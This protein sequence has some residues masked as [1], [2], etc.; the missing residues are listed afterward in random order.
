MSELLEFL[1]HIGQLFELPGLVIRSV[2]EPAVR[3]AFLRGT[4][5]SG[6]MVEKLLLH[7]GVRSFGRG[8]DGGTLWLHVPRHQANWAEYVM[9]R[10]GVPL[11]S[12][13]NPGNA[14]APIVPIPSWGRPLRPRGFLG[15]VLDLLG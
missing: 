14:K 10:H 9:R 12:A 5:W 15:K 13:Y 1:A 4:A 6:W 7:Y 8:F 3:F 11:V 2:R